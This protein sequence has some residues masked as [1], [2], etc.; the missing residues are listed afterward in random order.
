MRQ[1]FRY[2][3][4]VFL[5]R[6]SEG[7]K[8]CPEHGKQYPRGLCPRLNKEDKGG[9]RGS[10]SPCSLFSLDGTTSQ[11]PH[12]AKPSHHDERPFSEL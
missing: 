2:F 8:T 10:E 11:V 5:E 7:S 9:G 3:H 1:T 6:I 12:A 4:G